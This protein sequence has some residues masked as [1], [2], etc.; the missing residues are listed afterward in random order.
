M[1]STNILFTVL[2]SIVLISSSNSVQK[3]E[4]RRKKIFYPGQP[5][6]DTDSNLINAHGGSIYYED[7]TYYW[8]GEVH[9]KEI[10]SSFDGFRCYTSTDLYNWT[11]QGMVLPCTPD[12]NDYNYCDNELGNPYVIKNPKTGQYV[13]WTKMGLA[14]Y[15]AMGISVATADNPFGPFRVQHKVLPNDSI[16]H[17]GDFTLWQENGKAYVIFNSAHKNIVIA[18]LTDDYLGLTGKYSWH[19]SNEGP[20]EG[21]EAPAIMKANGRYFIIASGTT[22]YHPNAAEYAVA[23]HIHGPYEI[24]GNPCIGKDME[25][26]FDAQGRNILYLPEKEIY[27]F[28][29][30]RWE[31]L[32]VPS[33]TNVWLPI[34]IHGDSL[35][36][37]WKKEWSYN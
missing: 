37:E 8:Y 33:S 31:P 17:A 5:W 21:R 30:D 29:A 18:D 32:D 34:Q 4:N 1:K 9:D 14:G 35:A 3:K 23:D 13:L 2:L 10:A 25:T 6:Y 28:V 27:I 12:S 7:G 26:T 11:N 22:G 36:I 15:K 20:P 19:W 24:K 16:P